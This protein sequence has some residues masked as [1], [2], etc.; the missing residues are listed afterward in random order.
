MKPSKLLLAV[1]SAVTLVAADG[2]QSEAQAL[3]GHWLTQ[4]Q[5]AI[6]AFSACKANASDAPK[7][8]G[9][10]VWLAE[11]NNP[12]GTPKLDKNNDKADLRS[13]KLCGLRLIRDLTVSGEN[14][15]DDGS[16]YNPRT[17]ERFSVEIEKLSA[18]EIKMR[19]FL[20]ISLLG[21]SE[22]WTRVEDDRG[23][24]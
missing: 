17:G 7:V 4:N 9:D 24:C 8:C 2:I 13:R 11:P 23:G 14:R 21:K 1:A 15:W 18:A 3:D 16:I 22:V 6:V 20:G 10:M 12:D 5:K 19:G